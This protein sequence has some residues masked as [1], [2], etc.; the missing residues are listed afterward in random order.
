MAQSNSLIYIFERISEFN[1]HLVLPPF[2][3]IK[4]STAMNMFVIKSVCI[5]IAHPLNS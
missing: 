3:S 5:H 1:R 2:F 4:N